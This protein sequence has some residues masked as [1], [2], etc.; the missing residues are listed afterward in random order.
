M[1]KEGKWAREIIALQQEDGKWGW[2]HSLSRSYGAPLTT[3]QALR[4]LERLGFTME[5]ECIQRAVAYMDE[6][7]SGR[8]A[9]PDRPEKIHDWRIFTDLILTVWIRRFTPDNPRANRVAERW[10]GVLTAAYAGGAYD[11]SRYQ[12]AYRETFGMKPGGGRLMDFVNFYPLSLVQGW[13]SPDTENVLMDDVLHR[14]QG[15]YY[16]YDGRLVDPP[17]HFT[18]REASRYLAAMELLAGY[19]HAR[20]KLQF[21]AVWLMENQQPNG[22]WDMG[23]AV[24]DR[25]YFPLSDDWRRASVREEDCTQRIAAL[26]ERLNE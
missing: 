24:N 16:V 21:V 17:Q 14:K 5:D 20:G 19:R 25:V 7:L 26:L 2:F 13:L 22:R 10:A 11:H 6:C 12:E 1:H 23:K 3:E 15:V 18:S 9:I 8:L 4:R